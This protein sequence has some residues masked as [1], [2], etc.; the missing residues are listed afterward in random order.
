MIANVITRITVAKI[1]TSDSA[2]WK[3]QNVTKLQN[4]NNIIAII[5][6]ERT[7]YGRHGQ[8]A[9]SAEESLFLLI[10]TTFVVNWPSVI[11]IRLIYPRR[12]ITI[13]ICLNT[14]GFGVCK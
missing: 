1:D 10:I 4:A 2:T 14:A 3:Q 11:T 7:F 9:L 12:T 6:Y 13:N 8:T 5:F